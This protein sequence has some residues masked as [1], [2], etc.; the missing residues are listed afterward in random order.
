[1]TAAII[2]KP[3]PTLAVWA[4][5][6]PPRKF[7][8]VAILETDPPTL[9]LMAAFPDQARNVALLKKQLTE[10]Q[11]GRRLK[12]IDLTRAFP[13]RERNEWVLKQAIRILEDNPAPLPLPKLLLSNR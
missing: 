8:I 5:S 9:F 1:M 12:E 13:D 7:E 3:A 6:Q 4:D 2:T 11:S 10:M